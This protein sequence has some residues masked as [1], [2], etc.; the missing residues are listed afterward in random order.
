MSNEQLVQFLKLTDATVKQAE[1]ELNRF[2]SDRAEAVKGAPETAQLLV[3]TGYIPAA[4]V[5]VATERLSGH[6]STLALL[7]EVLGRQ[8]QSKQAATTPTAP[9]PLG[10]V[11]T[12]ATPTNPAPLTITNSGQRESYRAF[13]ESIGFR[14]HGG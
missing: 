14:P 9:A 10:R 5:K 11:L 8:L 12:P 7:R 13:D 3:Q 1:A 4:H 2:H 6:A